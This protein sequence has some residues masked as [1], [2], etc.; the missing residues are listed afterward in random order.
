ML[1]APDAAVLGVLQSVRERVRQHVSVAL[2]DLD[3]MTIAIS[4]G[5][6]EAAALLEYS[7]ERTVRS[8]AT[9]AVAKLALT[10]A[11]FITL[12]GTPDP[13]APRVRSSFGEK[14]LAA[15]EATPEA[16]ELQ[17]RLESALATTLLEDAQR[18]AWRT[19]AVIRVGAQVGLCRA[20]D[21]ARCLDAVVGGMVLA[22]ERRVDDLKND[23]EEAG[24]DIMV[25]AEAVSALAA[26]VV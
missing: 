25:I 13:T 17:R 20:T 2:P 6:V 21:A 19:S 11:E 5:M 16:K 1:A 18:T 9:A 7:Q 12:F 3:A 4:A 10:D 14:R 24:L 15:Y 23:V 26:S 8:D 22:D